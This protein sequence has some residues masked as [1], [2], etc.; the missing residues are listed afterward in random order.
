ME[1]GERVVRVVILRSMLKTLEKPVTEGHVLQIGCLKLV[2]VVRS[3][4]SLTGDS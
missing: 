1:K 2:L 3:I 4:C